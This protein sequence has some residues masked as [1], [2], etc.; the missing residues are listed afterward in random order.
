M[1]ANSAAAR[2][3]QR[4]RRRQAAYPTN[5]AVETDGRNDMKS[6]ALALIV[7][8]GLGLAAS[9]AASAAPASGAPLA[10]A[11]GSLDNVDR[12]WFDRFGRWHPN[13]RVLIAPRLIPACRT[14]RVCGPRG[15]CWLER[16]CY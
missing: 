9:S 14:V 6:V 2:L 4:H 13:R 12:V 5:N 16:R 7:A 1:A 8:I 11:A 10:A 3:D 15:R